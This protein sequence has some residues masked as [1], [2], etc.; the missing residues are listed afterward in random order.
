VAGMREVIAQASAA[1]AS[2]NG[3]FVQYD[4]TSVDW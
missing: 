3:R 1:R 2:F 4:G